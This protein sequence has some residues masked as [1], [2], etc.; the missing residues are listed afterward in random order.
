MAQVY[1]PIYNKLVKDDKDLVGLIAYALY[2]QH[3]IEF[4][5]SFKASHDNADPKQGDF[6]SFYVGSCTTSSLNSYRDEAQILLE[7]LTLAAAREEIDAFENE[8]LQDYKKE[9]AEAVKSNQPK[10]W[11]SVIYSV[12]GAF[13]FSII[14]A[15]SSFLGKTSEKQNMQLIID[16]INSVRTDS[17]K[18]DPPVDA[19]VF[20]IPEQNK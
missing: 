7:K 18:T 10:W 9:I 1:N 12:I 13:V 3:K 17:T 14:V 11:N 4:I 8:M 19:Q 6:E 20:D 2:K 5:K 16:A 15:M